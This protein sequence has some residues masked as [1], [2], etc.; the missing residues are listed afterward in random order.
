MMRQFQK[1]FCLS[2]DVLVLSSLEGRSQN[3]ERG[4]LVLTEASLGRL[5]LACFGDRG[6]FG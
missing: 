3:I 2:L 4:E 6:F 5:L 1:V